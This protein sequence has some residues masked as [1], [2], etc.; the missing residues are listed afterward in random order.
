M[1]DDGFELR[2][3]SEEGEMFD[4]LRGEEGGKEEV[5]RLLRT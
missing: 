3:E 2:V 4:L 1:V 5:V